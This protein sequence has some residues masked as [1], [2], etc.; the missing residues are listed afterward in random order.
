MPDPALAIV[1]LL[2]EDAE[3]RRQA[4]SAVDARDASGR[5]A[6]REALLGDEDAEVRARAA[7]KLGEAR[8][9]RFV[10]ALCEALR[11]AMPSVRDR[12]IRAL[13]RIGA[14]EILPH[15]RRAVR[16]E[17]V[18]WVRRAAVRAA[19]SVG[20]VD[21]LEISIEALADPFWRVRHAA[22]QSLV[23]LGDDEEVSAEVRTRVQAAAKEDGSGAVA[24]AATYLAQT[25]GDVRGESPPAQGADAP[26][27]PWST[28]GI[29]D[30]DPAVV[31]A[32]L[33]RTSAA[34]LPVRALVGWLGDPHAP[35]RSLARR[36]LR[37]RGDREAMILAT[38]WLDEPR[39][40]HA[41]G[42]VRAL[43][44]RLGGED[45]TLAEEILAAAPSPGPLRWAAAVA[46]T[47]RHRG[48]LERVRSF[49]K[50]ASPSMRRAAIAGL[51]RE[52]ESLPIVL[53]ALSDP[54]EAVR[55]EV[56]A[57]WEKQTRARR[58]Q[59]L[60][61][62]VHALCD[63]AP[64]ARSARERRA[65][66]EAAAIAGDEAL[67]A[68][69]SQDLDPSVRATALAARAARGTLRDEER[70]A[71]ETHEDPWIRA[72]VLDPDSAARAC[73]GD[74]DPWVRR[75]AIALLAS[76]RST[77]PSELLRPAALVSARSPDPWVRARA[78]D[79]LDPGAHAEDL[80]ALL[81]MS[82]DHHPMARASAASALEACD[83]LD[84]RLHALL[85]GPA[86]ERDEDVR[87]SAFTWLLRRADDAAFAHLC[88]ALR[89]PTEPAPVAAHLEALTL[90]FP[91][92]AFDAAPD[93]A[94]R[95][96]SPPQ[97]PPTTAPRPRPLPARSPALR[98][99]GR[100]G[101]SVSPLVLSG[102]H[103][104]PSAAL[105]E[106]REAGVNA[107]FWEPRYAE[108]TR[109][110]RSRR[111]G[112]ED[113]VVIAGTYNAGAEA[114]R[115]DVERA[116]ARLR[117]DWIDVFLLF[118]VRSRER[119]SRADHDALAQLAAEGKVR[120]FGFSTHDRAIC[121][122]A[123]V[124]ASWPVVMTRHSAAHPGAEETV[125]P[126]ARARGTGVLTFTATS[127]GRLLRPVPGDDPEAQT[128]S[129]A[130]CY[131]YSLSQPGVSACLCA[132]RSRKELL[133]NLAVLGEPRITPEVAS[134]LRAHGERVRAHHRRFDAL[135]RR[136]PGG[137]KDTLRALLDEDTPYVREALPS[138]P[139]M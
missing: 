119:L 111:A 106:A 98:P 5:Y 15:A 138:E 120:A 25:W 115:K 22:V 88:D 30:E 39:V 36:R 137:P 31:T 56:L 104:V 108:L 68:R 32:R 129:A 112:R 29:G 18:W 57:R 73:A 134:S 131:R 2:D 50:H 60:D 77:L 117:T 41:A 135:V 16:E 9:R 62:W 45:I 107:F 114:I 102:A 12:A 89:D 122:E 43:L 124:E 61:A 37:E 126:E 6:L 94:H 82:R 49:A 42:E 133:E 44:D 1:R 75:A 28:N 72:S 90:V 7:Q 93:L 64:H 69:A 8:D 26:S 54:D 96:P 128:A 121:R 21:A 118:W 87:T 38:R 35:L 67:L 97:R 34:E 105:A 81:V 51:A 84:A 65:V 99:L 33:E 52:P 139:E 100:T 20:G 85:R 59:A 127:Y 70:R 83:A 116:L 4:V 71:A 46:A 80:R 130:D 11:D 113:I 66:A 58:S 92:E 23:L 27:F 55:D 14:E 110:L 74:P 19:A 47:R 76:R 123:L 79:L 40:P 136:G 10:P 78:A 63:F 125:F 48:L 91:D 17:A 24:A 86:R 13:A 132:P 109:F 3:V 101:L 103:G 95:R 53:A